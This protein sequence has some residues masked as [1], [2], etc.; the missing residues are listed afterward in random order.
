MLRCLRPVF[1]KDDVK[2]VVLKKRLPNEYHAVALVRVDAQRLLLDNL[3]LT[4]VRDKE[5]TRAIP[6]FVLDEDGLR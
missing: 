3:T 5:V 1:P 6:G 4:L 2:I